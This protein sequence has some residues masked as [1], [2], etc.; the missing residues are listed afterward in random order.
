[1]EGR[2]LHK[3]LAAAVAGIAVAAAVVAGAHVV[4]PAQSTCDAGRDYGY[5]Y[6]GAKS[7]SVDFVRSAMDE[8]SL[9]VLGSSEFSTP[10]KTVPQIPAQTFGTANYGLRPMLVGEAFDQCLWDTIALGAFADGGLPRDKVVVIVGLGQFTDGGLDASTFGERFSYSLYQR[11]CANES[12]PDELRDYVRRRLAEQG[13]DETTIRAGMPSNPI[14]S[15]DGIVL[16]DMD[17][18]RLRSQLADVRSRGV[19]LAGGDATQPDWEALRA[20]GLATAEQMS[21]NNDWGAEDEFYASQ[22]APA[23]DK[24]KDAR[25]GETYTDTPEYDDLDCF[26]DTCEACGVQPLVVVQPVL[27]PYYDHIGITRE[28]REAAYQRIRD[29]VAE[30]AN[31]QIADFSDREYEKYFLFDIVHFGWTGWI[32]AEHAIY[33]FAMGGAGNG[34]S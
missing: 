11:F 24:L 15:I 19:E 22:L 3:R 32:D 26:L 4:L 7:S 2:T 17:D 21:T 33:D 5:V 9:L 1:M 31:A 28:T 25:A 12:I 14:E 18:L 16:A 20:E 27:G 29:I 10:A 34:A 30:H 23:L 6:S 13:V 8:S